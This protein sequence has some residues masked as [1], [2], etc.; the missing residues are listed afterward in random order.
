LSGEKHNSIYKI[1][2][3]RNYCRF[4]GAREG[5]ALAVPSLFY[6]FWKRWNSPYINHFISPDSIIPDQTSPQSWDRY[7]YV[8]NNPIRYT[9]PSGHSVDCAVGEQYCQAGKLNVTQRANDLYRDR[10]YRDKRNHQTTG[11]NELSSDER[12]ILSEGNWD[13]GGYNDNG[14]VSKADPL[15]DPAVYI[16]FVFGGWASGL[17]ET[18]FW[19]GATACI[20]NPICSTVTGMAGG[21]GAIEET[22]PDLTNEKLEHVFGNPDHNLEPLLQSFDNNQQAAFT[23]T[24]NE[25]ATVAENYS[26]RELA[27]GIPVTVGDVIVVVRG[28][29]VNGIARIGTFFIPQ[30]N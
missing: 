16:S 7:A 5:W 27:D 1:S 20:S 9:D 6:A 30:D 17:S 8:M 29:M 12:S 21:A 4:G 11:W 15:H 28:A 10:K 3:G 22:I 25:F 18:S 13:R 2:L 14:G 23:A 26:Q 19:T 24:Y